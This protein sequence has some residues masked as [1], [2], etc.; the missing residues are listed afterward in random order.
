MKAVR[1]DSDRLARLK[2]ATSLVMVRLTS[3]GAY[4]HSDWI[5]DCTA[6]RR[7]RHLLVRN[8]AHGLSTVIRLQPP[9]LAFFSLNLKRQDKTRR[10]YEYR[11]VASTAWL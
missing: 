3:D 8:E 7:R 11:N 2:H 6:R 5:P 1:L 4:V 10:K 9:W